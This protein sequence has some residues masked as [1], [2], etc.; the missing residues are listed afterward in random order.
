VALD[1]GLPGA[2]NADYPITRIPV[3]KEQV[4]TRANPL[5][6]T[7]QDGILFLDGSRG[8]NGKGSTIPPGSGSQDPVDSRRLATDEI[9]QEFTPAG[10]DGPFQLR[11][12][13]RVTLPPI[14]GASP[15]TPAFQPDAVYSPDGYFIGNFPTN[16]AA[17][18]SRGASNAPGPGF[19]SQLTDALNTAGKRAVPVLTRVGNFIGDNLTTPAEGA[20][21]LGPLLR[22]PTVPNLPGD[23]TQ[24]LFS[25]KPERRLSRRIVNPSASA[26]QATPDDGASFSDRFGNRT[27][28]PESIAPFN[29][30]LAAAPPEPRRPLGIFSG[31]PMP[32]WTVPPPLGGLS[33]NSNTST[34]WYTAL[35]GNFLPTAGGANDRRDAREPQ[36]SQGP[37]S[38]ND[39]YLEYVA[40]LNRN[41]PE[42]STFD[43]S[44]PTA[45]FDAS[46]PSAFSGGLLGRYV[47]LAGL[48]PENLNLPALPPLD[49]EQEQANLQALDAK[50]S[51][52]GD[53]RDAV[54][55][56]KAREASRR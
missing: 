17:T 49:D 46:D 29:P 41:K 14:E 42:A 19:G 7:P 21:P 26:S 40:R 33:N 25:D 53:I 6:V 24:G 2:N 34:N 1:L 47:A 5:A 39:A 35:G 36:E 50:L 27:S 51:S 32:V 44:A 31:K 11:R 13:D 30:N 54:A 9:G 52:A 56:Y 20:S 18:S 8:Y 10:S 4:C 43:P 16:S 38:L 48:D 3:D 23:E 28:P 15:P 45:P 37:L 12:R 22:D 55:L